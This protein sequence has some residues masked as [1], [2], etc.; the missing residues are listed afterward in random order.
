M[1]TP[2]R[3]RLPMLAAA[4]LAAG[5]AAGGGT[6]ALWN[7]GDP[8]PAATIVAGDLAA[9]AGAVTWTET[10]PD[11][12]AAPHTVDPEDF[13]VRRGDTFTADYDFTI[14]LDGDN[15]RAAIDVSWND[16]PDLP[17]GATGSFS[18]LDGSGAVLAS[19][20]TIGDDQEVVA[21]IDP[22][23]TMET[24]YTLRFE[25]DFGGIDDRFGAAS[26]AQVADLGEIAVSLRQIRTGGG[27]Q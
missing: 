21:D 18:L 1:R 24:D 9:E 11:V 20:L 7:G 27:F 14:A 4:A 3:W 10:S 22:S 17:A 25:L 19:G 12:S 8:V 23:P 5:A 13:L 16:S 26:A 6:L 15:M 2:I